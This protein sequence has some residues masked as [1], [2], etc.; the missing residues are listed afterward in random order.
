MRGN[1]RKSSILERRG[2][3]HAGFEEVIDREGGDRRGCA[4]RDVAATRGRRRAEEN[5]GVKGGR[6]LRDAFVIARKNMMALFA[7]L[8]DPRKSCERR[9]WCG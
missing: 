3:L 6:A 9:D 8:S 5:K 2:D 1:P 4:H 7:Y